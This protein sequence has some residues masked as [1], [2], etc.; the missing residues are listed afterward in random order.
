MKE[1]CILVFRFSAMGDVAMTAPVLQQ[2][3]EKYSSI[4]IVMVSRPLFKPFFE[5]IPNLIFHAIQ[6]DSIHKGLKGLYKLFIEL[7]QYNPHAIADLHDNLR[8]RILSFYFR[9][10]GVQIKRI[11]KGREEKRAL[12]R[13]NNKIL[14]PLQLTVDRYADV[15]C[16]LN[17]P[18]SLQHMLKKQKRPIPP[19]F[20]RYYENKRLPIIGIAPFAQHIYKMYPLTLM[21]EVI[22][23]LSK[24]YQLF[25][26]G[27]GDEEK[28]I[29]E[30]WEKKHHAVASVIGKI[31]LE[32]E[33]N[34]IANIDL[35]LS[36]DSSGM[37][38][39]S[40]VGVRVVSIWG[41]THPYAGFLGFG[42]LES[43][44]LQINH[45]SRPNSVYGNKPCLC[46]NVPCIELIEPKLVINKI[47][48]LLKHG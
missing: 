42:Q 41:P 14:K 28:K 40:L 21:E 37:H 33:L 19:L 47:K 29:A 45:P 17:Y 30:E 7:K 32:Q 34:L 20:H 11:D 12:T 15:F 25:I 4:K 35:M 6:P 27:G 8:S 31:N 3:C 24:S 46:D 48:Q 16:A 36:M 9:S 44:C 2:L 5:H 26:F 13:T 23:D 38:L 39:A 18:L 10:T 1:K 22:A 43:D